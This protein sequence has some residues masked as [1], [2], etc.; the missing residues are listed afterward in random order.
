MT[1]AVSGD[2]VWRAA[3][4]CAAGDPEGEEIRRSQGLW[5]LA[6]R[7]EWP[8][9]D[10][11]CGGDVFGPVLTPGEFVA[12]RCWVR[13]EADDLA[14]TRHACDVAWRRWTGVDDDGFEV[15][16]DPEDEA[17]DPFGYPDMDGGSVVLAFDARD[18]EDPFPDRARTCL[19]ILVEELRRHGCTP[20]RL[21]NLLHLPD[22]EGV[23]VEA[24]ADELAA[25]GEPRPVERRAAVRPDWLPAFHEVDR[26]RAGRPDGPVPFVLLANGNAR[27]WDPHRGLLT[28]PRAEPDAD[29]SSVVMELTSLSADG[30][31]LHYR[32]RAS[33][34]S[35]T[36]T[37]TRGRLEVRSGAVTLATDIATDVYDSP[38]GDLRLEVERP[39][40]G[41]TPEDMH[42]RYR[43]VDRSGVSRDLPLRDLLA[44]TDAGPAAQFSPSGRLL[45][46]S[47][48]RPT[49]SRAYLV[50]T[51][52]A[53]GQSQEYLDR[54]WLRGN[55]AWSPDET[56]LLV[57]NGND[58][59]VLDLATG[60][61]ED[62]P[63]DRLGPDDPGP[64]R[65]A[66]L[67][68]LDDHGLL[69]TLRH[70]RRLRLAYQSVHDAT[71]HHVLDI[72]VAAPDNT[73]GLTLATT[74]LRESP[75]LIGCHPR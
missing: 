13:V 68:W 53:T 4:E 60:R 18:D 75:H 69:M 73:L 41:V 32:R 62:V 46:T 61:R 49:D 29:A 12:M 63:V 19:R 2:D 71:R 36:W 10:V 72:P 7:T 56:R 57:Q 9:P 70:G 1:G 16:L 39:P 31:S 6:V 23:D 47:H 38:A 14:R 67:G 25:A 24:L 17:L 21:T 43:L 54:A 55:P 59:V 45:V 15:G 37:L 40:R 50:R 51:D 48:H 52:L 28:L 44:P 58:P 3:L 64:G 30:T 35:E 27:A 11:R 20:V 22:D 66:P 65:W 26:A 42:S 5:A 33:P 8:D 34:E 74:L